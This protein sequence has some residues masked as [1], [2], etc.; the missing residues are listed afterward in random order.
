MSSGPGRHDPDYEERGHD[1]P[2]AYVRWTEGRN[3]E[4]F[5]DL[6]AA[7]RIDVKPLITHRFRIDD[8]A[9]AYQLISGKLNENYLAVQ[10]EYDRESEVSRRIE[11]RS[12]TKKAAGARGGLGLLGAGGS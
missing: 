7:K 12:A 9:E 3:I 5:L 8:A 6:L 11:N 10:L 1:Y 2:V 4:A